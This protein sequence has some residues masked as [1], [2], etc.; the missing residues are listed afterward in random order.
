MAAGQQRL[1]AELKVCKVAVRIR[2]DCILK[3]GLC[4]FGPPQVG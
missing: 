2:L 1:V 3:G 4:L